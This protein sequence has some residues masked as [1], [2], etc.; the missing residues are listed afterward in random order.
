MCQKYRN[1]Q[2]FLDENTEGGNYCSCGKGNTSSSINNNKAYTSVITYTHIQ[3]IQ[4]K[5]RRNTW[6][7]QYIRQWLQW[8]ITWQVCKWIAI[9]EKREKDQFYK[10][11]A[12]LVHDFT[13]SG[14]MHTLEKSAKA[15]WVTFFSIV[16]N[17][18]VLLACLLE[19]LSPSYQNMATRNK[20]FNFCVVCGIMYRPWDIFYTNVFVSTRRESS[21]KMNFLQSKA[22]LWKKDVSR[23]KCGI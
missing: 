22:S 6:S 7:L 15:Y 18:S 16:L 20:T 8:K 13:R 17:T 5:S 23:M 11:K 14:E 10:L 19:P 3:D 21:L 4:Q 12:R 1:Q 9:F 2:L